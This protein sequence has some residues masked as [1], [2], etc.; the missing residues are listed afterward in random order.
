MGFRLDSIIKKKFVQG[1]FAISADYT[2]DTY[3]ISGGEGSFSLQVDYSEGI[4]LDMDMYLEVSTNGLAFVRVD[5]S[6]QNVVDTSGTHVWDVS[7]MGVV[8][9]RV[10]F[11]VNAGSC[12]LD[13][14]DL[15]AKRRH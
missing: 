8:Y 7:E 14:V 10:A 6:L 13:D 5:E 9:L 12:N 1:P 15:S 2:T 11:V 3:D 4:A